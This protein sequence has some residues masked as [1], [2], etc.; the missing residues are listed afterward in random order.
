MPMRIMPPGTGS[1][2]KIVTPYPFRASQS[3]APNPAGPEPMIAILSVRLRG[4]GSF[5]ASPSRREA[6]SI[7]APSPLEGESLC[8]PSPLE[9]E[10]WGEGEFSIANLFSP[11]IETASPYLACWHSPSHGRWHT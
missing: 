8:T 1:A 11:R 7:C 5:P 3:A 10:G 6:E 2:S 4:G 9:G